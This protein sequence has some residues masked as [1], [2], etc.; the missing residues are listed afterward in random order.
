MRNAIAY[1]YPRVTASIRE[2]VP[3]EMIADED[4]NAQ[5]TVTGK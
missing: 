4:D 5:L 2:H 1:V 3:I